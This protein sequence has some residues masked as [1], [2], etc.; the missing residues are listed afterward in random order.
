MSAEIPTEVVTPPMRA[1][2][3]WSHG[4]TWDR[5]PQRTVHASKHWITP[6]GDLQFG[7]D[8]YTS[9]SFMRGS[10]SRVAPAE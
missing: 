5:I 1:W 9:H 6:E 10:W 2:H 4:A 8:Y 3:V 7:T